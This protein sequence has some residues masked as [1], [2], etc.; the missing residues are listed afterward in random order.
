MTTAPSQSFSF[1]N[2]I[3]LPSCVCTLKTS[4]E[5]KPVPLARIQHCKQPHRGTKTK[6]RDCR[7]SNWGYRGASLSAFPLETYHCHSDFL[8]VSS[9]AAADDRHCPQ[10]DVA[11]VV[12]VSHWRMTSRRRPWQPVKCGCRVLVW[13]GGGGGVLQFNSNLSSEW[14]GSHQTKLKP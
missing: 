2:W 8:C 9:K 5:E 7:G 1:F 4:L 10:D 6:S 13:V 11:E 12:A 14:I 3:S